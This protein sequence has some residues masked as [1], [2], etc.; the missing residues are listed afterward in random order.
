VAPKPKEFLTLPGKQ[1]S[2]PQTAHQLTPPLPPLAHEVPAPAAP[3]EIPPPKKAP[4]LLIPSKPSENAA[5]QP[6]QAAPA[7]P[8]GC[9]C[10]ECAKKGI[11]SEVLV[12]DALVEQ[13][14]ENLE[15]AER[16]HPENC[17]C[18]ACTKKGVQAAAAELGS[19]DFDSDARVVRLDKVLQALDTQRHT[20]SGDV[21]TSPDKDYV[22]LARAQL[23][24]GS[25]VIQRCHYES[26]KSI[27]MLTS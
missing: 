24:R 1:S 20:L 10:A 16:A 17:R 4:K 6:G 11:E 2:D 12:E 19:Y 27:G 22:S 23:K 25:E 14:E 5:E 3:L 15:P 8:K 26:P 7:H 9:R 13:A 18:V 21:V